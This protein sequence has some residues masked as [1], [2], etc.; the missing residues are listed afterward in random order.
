MNLELPL[1]PNYI[2]VR[3]DRRQRVRVLEVPGILSVVGFGAMPAALPDPEIEAIRSAVGRRKMEPHPYLVIGERVRIQAGPMTGWEGVL[4]R[5]KNNLRVVLT[6]DAIMKSVAVEVAHPEITRFFMT[7]SEAVSLVLQAFAIGR[8]G[9]V[10]VLDMGEPVRIAD[11]A[12]T[13][14]RL[15]GRSAHEFKF[16]GLRPG[17]KLFEELFYAEERVY[18]SACAK[19]ACAEGAKSDWPELQQKLDRLR[20]AIATGHRASILAHLRQIVPQFTYG[21]W[22]REGNSEGMPLPPNLG[23]TGPEAPMGLDGSVPPHR[24]WR[25][26][27]SHE[28]DA[29]M[30][31]VD[32][33][34]GEATRPGNAGPGIPAATAPRFPA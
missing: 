6:L 29:T 4:V 9:D 27:P 24:N 25:R 3:I 11:L 19:I 26:T 14:V 33:A 18:P 1:F 10:L 21:G 7:I 2:F 15:S 17:E 20:V 34:N 8:N 31:L 12:R 23:A 5:K 30:P 16:I 28:A 13:L 32:V 22:D